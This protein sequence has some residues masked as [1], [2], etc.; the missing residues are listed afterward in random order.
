MFLLRKW[1]SFVP[2]APEIP[3]SKFSGVLNTVAKIWKLYYSPFLTYPTAFSQNTLLLRKWLTF[4]PRTPEIPISKFLGVL[5]TM[6]KVWK[7]YYSPFLR[8]PQHF[9][10]T[11]FCW[12]SDFFSFLELQKYPLYETASAKRRV[13]CWSMLS[14]RAYLKQ[15]V[16]LGQV[17]RWNVQTFPTTSQMKWPRSDVRWSTQISCQIYPP[18]LSRWSN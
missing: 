9:L 4:V 7:L 2:G 11:H 17:F 13:L 16:E 12:E 18:E 5:N 14:M 6:A 8:Y 3:T 15:M 10:K 1:L